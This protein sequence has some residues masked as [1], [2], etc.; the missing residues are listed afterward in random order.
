M[1]D[2]PR[3]KI[4]PELYLAFHIGMKPKDLIEKGY[5]NTSVYNYHRR[6]K[7]EVKPAFEELLKNVH[8]DNST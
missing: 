3:A 2:M 7:K 5:K 1:I 4:M 6:F 8:N